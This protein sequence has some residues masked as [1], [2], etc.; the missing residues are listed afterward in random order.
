MPVYKYK[1]IDES[2]KAVQGV[3]DADSPKGASEKLKRQGVFISALHE[4][5]ESF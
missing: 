5:K 2:G 3:I 4:A 1:A